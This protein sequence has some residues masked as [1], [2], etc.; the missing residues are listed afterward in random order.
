MSLAAVF[1]MSAGALAAAPASPSG[2]ASLGGQP[3]PA[4]PSGPSG[5]ASLRSADTS[6]SSRSKG[7]TQSTGSHSTGSRS[8]AHSGGTGSPPFTR[9][10]RIGDHGA[11]VSTL[12]AWLAKVGIA[13]TVDGTFGAATKASVAEFQRDAHLS[14]V[15]GIAGPATEGSL[16]GW[17]QAGKQVPAPPPPAT[18][19]APADWVFPL[20]PLALVLPPSSWTL[21]QGVDIGTVG[22]ACG[23]SVVEV[24]VTAGTIVQ[25]G[26]SGF[27][28]YAP[29][30]KVS[31]GPLAGRYVYYGHA[32]PALVPVGTSVTAGEPIADVGCGD[33]GISSGPHLEIG[34][35]APGGPTCCPN[36]DETSAQMLQIV[37]ELYG[38]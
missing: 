30:L 10:L 27:G 11:D 8:T 22:N 25:E 2:G 19:T 32:A 31:S 23:S 35:S 29:V 21:D 1:S 33:V 12:Q 16:E 15:D 5:G 4:R 34:I 14:P 28:P 36:V 17:V 37:K 13:T 26:I 38:S 18:T 3:A 6:G 24:A 9:T 20:R 7:S